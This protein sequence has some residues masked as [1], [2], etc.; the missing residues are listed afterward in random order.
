[1]GQPFRWRKQLCERIAPEALAFSPVRIETSADEPAACAHD[2][3]LRKRPSRPAG[4][5]AIELVSGD[6]VPVVPS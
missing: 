3:L 4:R 5:I 1:M 6:W 2:A